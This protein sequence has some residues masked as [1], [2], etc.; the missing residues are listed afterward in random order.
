MRNRIYKLLVAVIALIMLVS[1][2]P[3]SAAP[4]ADIPAKML[5]NIY[6]DAL[7]YTGYKTDVQKADGSIFK[8]YS[9]NAPAS[10]RS[11]IG[12]GTGPSGLETVT[13]KENGETVKLNI[14]NSKVPEPP[15]APESPKTGDTANILIPS[16]AL[17]TALAAVIY[18][19]EKIK[20]RGY[21]NE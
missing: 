5:D 11:G 7:T 4:A 6:L 21:I 12:Y 9:G 14:K 1:A 17:F 10:V 18:L 20:K 13:V 2:L 16:A 8:T 3:L 15:S 19:S